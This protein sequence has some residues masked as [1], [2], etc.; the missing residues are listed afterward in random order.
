MAKPNHPRLDYCKL[1]LLQK[2]KTSEE[3]PE[4]ARTVLEQGKECLLKAS[5]QTF[6]LTLPRHRDESSLWRLARPKGFSDN[7]Q[8][9]DR[10]G[11]G[12]SDGV[13]LWMRDLV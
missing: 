13:L 8:A 1:R 12:A 5:L 3:L 11:Y 9:R 4:V 7:R 2:A 10:E 6:R